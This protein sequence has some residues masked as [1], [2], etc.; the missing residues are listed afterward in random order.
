MP[1][2]DSS[3]I[4]ED[5]LLATI[6][7]ANSLE[8][9]YDLF[10]KH[11]LGVQNE[12][13]ITNPLGNNYLLTGI[14]FVLFVLFVWLYVTKRQRLIQIIKDFYQIQ[15]GNVNRRYEFSN[16][17]IVSIVLS[18]FFIATIT[19]FFIQVTSYHGIRLGYTYDIAILCASVISVVYAIKLIVIKLMGFIFQEQNK[20]NEYLT[21]IVLFANVIG[22]FMLP[23]VICLAFLKQLPA[24][25]FVNVGMLLLVLFFI[26]RLA[27]GMSIG[28]KS[29]AISKIYLFM[30]LCALEILPFILMFKLFAYSFE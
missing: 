20:A 23:L 27:K 3:L 22:L 21:S 8:N 30:Y 9:S 28:L 14:L 29:P 2:I 4:K 24:A 6:A 19:L 1:F 18:I 13:P 11:L 26:L 17:N 10:E 7:K 16:T 12:G 25:L 5:S 15:A